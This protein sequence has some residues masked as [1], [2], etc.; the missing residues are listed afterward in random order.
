MLADP[1]CPVCLGWSDGDP[2]CPRHGGTYQ[3]GMECPAGGPD[4]MVIVCQRGAAYLCL[5]CLD[6]LEDALG[7]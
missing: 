4:H 3:E 6:I 2:A 1:T 5:T 7:G